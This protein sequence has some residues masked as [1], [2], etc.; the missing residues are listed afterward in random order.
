LQARFL[1]Y[2]PEKSEFIQNAALYPR[3]TACVFDRQLTPT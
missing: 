3:Q 2:L 1:N